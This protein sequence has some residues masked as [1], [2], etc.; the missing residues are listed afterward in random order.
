M[1][2]TFSLLQQA[3]LNTSRPPPVQDTL[4]PDFTEYQPGPPPPPQCKPPPYYPS[5]HPPPHV[6]FPKQVDT[7]TKM[8][9]EF[10]RKVGFM[11]G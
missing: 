11:P 4:K 10:P 1:S 3:T 6:Q 5:H 7:A 9:K 8:C 2:E